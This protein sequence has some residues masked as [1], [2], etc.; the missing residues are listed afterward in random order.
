[1]VNIP[2]PH[3]SLDSDTDLLLFLANPPILGWTSL[4]NYGRKH[5]SRFDASGKSPYKCWYSEAPLYGNHAKS[6]DH[7]RPKNSGDSLKGILI[8]SD[9][10]PINDVPQCQAWPVTKGYTWL[11]Y[12]H[13]NYRLSSPNSNYSGGKHN[14]FPIF[15]GTSHLGFGQGIKGINIH[16]NEFPLLLD[17]VN[18]LDC[19]LLKVD[20]KDGRIIPLYPRANPPAN[21]MSNPINHYSSDWM[22]WL[23][24]EVSIHLYKLNHEDFIRGRQI[25]YGDTVKFFKAYLADPNAERKETLFTAIRIFSPFCLAARC[26]VLDFQLSPLANASEKQ[27]LKVHKHLII[28]QIRKEE[29]PDST[30][31]LI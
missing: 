14:F 17:P 3:S 5:T 21:W 28:D 10:L 15:L 11:E 24:A 20:Q 26:A 27:E 23:R 13:F 2:Y 8:G 19:G 4:F 9:W 7:F 29:G 25:V 1:M 30:F 12:D 16:G 18:P 6:I 22:K 31:P